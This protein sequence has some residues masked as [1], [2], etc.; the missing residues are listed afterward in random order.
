[1]KELIADK[2]VY[3]EGYDVSVST[4]LTYAQIQQIANA[5]AQLDTWAERQQNIDML[6]LL[7]ATDIETETLMNT[8]ADIFLTSGLVRKVK[9]II[10]NYND[11]YEAIKYTESTQNTI[12]NFIKVLGNLPALEDKQNAAS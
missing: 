12:K 9:G 2:K 3:L 5:T 6:V 10:R 7:H 8:D 11:I 4:Y 1:M